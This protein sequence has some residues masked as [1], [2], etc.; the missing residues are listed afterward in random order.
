MTILD[1]MRTP[2]VF[3]PSRSAYKDWLH[4]CVVDHA[5]GAIGFVNTS[6]SGPA[7]DIRSRAA[8]IALVNAPWGAGGEDAWWGGVEILDL[9]EARVGVSSIALRRVATAVHGLDAGVD[10]SARMP[11]DGLDLRI[12]AKSKAA[13]V[14]VEEA[15]SLGDG[16]ISWLAVPRLA[17]SGTIRLGGRALELDDASAYWDHNWGRWRW[18]DDFGWDWGVF[19]APAPGISVVCSRVTDRG[20]RRYNDSLLVVQL[21]AMRRTF[22]GDSVQWTSGR[23]LLGATPRRLP[24]AVAAL[25]QDRA[26]PLL[27]RTTVVAAND[28]IDSV[29]IEF[30][31]RAVA[32]LLMAD[33]VVRG[34]SCVHEVVG[35]F[36]AVGS[37][38]GVDVDSG[39]LGILERVD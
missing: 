34:Y 19:L 28:G 36:T 33:P 10:V 16:W 21:G 1:W 39:G 13:P 17:V 12:H 18:G 9:D 27:S 14:R 23:E 32:Q 37:L 6:L 5:S 30:T 7:D 29:R 11:D 3:D 26:R 24:G 31:G 4:L 38:G 2:S 22:C 35:E 20:H 15:V 8:G 25:Y